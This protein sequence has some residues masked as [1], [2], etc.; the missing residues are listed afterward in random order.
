M[1]HLPDATVSAIL[2]FVK[3]DSYAIVGPVCRDFE[4]QYKPSEK[5]TRTSKY[6]QSSALFQQAPNTIQLKSPSLLDDLISRGEIEVI[7]LV[8]SRG[9]EWNHFCVERAAELGSYEFFEWLRSTELAWLPEV[10]H[11]AA[12]LS[13]NVQMMTYLVESG[14]GFPSC[15]SCAVA[16]DR[17]VREWLREVLLDPA[18]IFVTA[19]RED[20]VCVFQQTDFLE[21][22]CLN[23]MC[24]REACNSGSVNVLEFFRRFVDV[25]P[26]ATD[27][28][29]AL[30][31]QRVEVAE[32]CSEFFPDLI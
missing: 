3:T 24:I 29:A 18:L 1:L 9:Y 5:V 6:T 10:A 32:W 11:R 21:D 30:H 7:P 4:K 16:K 15:R 8:L 25:G 26:T 14:A 12:A 13:G 20:D 27:V 31:F 17:R 19:A 22:H 2:D 28:A 23:R